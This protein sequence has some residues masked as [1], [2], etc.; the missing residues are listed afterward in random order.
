MC[1]RRPGVAAILI[2]VALALWGAVAPNA[3]AATGLE[4]F[5]PG[6]LIS[7]EAFFD[8]ETM[9]EEEIAAFIAGRGASCQPNPDGTPCLKDYRSDTPAMPDSP[10]C[11]AL[12]A[13]AGDS[14]AGMITRVAGAC[15]INPQ[16]L[17][18]LLQ[19]EQGFLTATG[20][21]LTPQKYSRA[22]G[23]GC[24]DFGTCD[25]TTATFFLQLYSAGERFQKYRVLS[26]SYTFQANSWEEIGYHPDSACGKARVFVQNQA[27][28]GL[29]NYTPY[30]PNEASLAAVAGTGDACS[31]YGNRNF[32]RYMKTWFPE[33][34]NTSD[35]APVAPT[36]LAPAP[37]A[38]APLA[39]APTAAAAPTSVP[40]QTA[41]P[42]PSTTASV[43]PG[44]AAI[45][46]AAA[47]AGADEVGTPASGP[48]CGP[49]S[50]T[51][52]YTL[53][54]YHWTPATGANFVRGAIGELWSAQGGTTGF[55][56]HPTSDEFC[57]LAQGGCGQHFEGGS[58]FHSPA[59][60]TFFSLGAIRDLW[61]DNAWEEGFLGYP[62]S[63][64]FC[65]LDQAGCAQHFQG[66]SIY[67]TPALG[68][69]FTRGLVRDLW[70]GRGWERGTLG[71][72]TTDEL[73]AADASCRQDFQG[74]AIAYTVAGGAVLA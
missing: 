17:L 48:E 74:G 22:L 35:A 29:Y 70:A 43:S 53:A 38:P 49:A 63:D 28:A 19:K 2:A 9:D 65:G 55:L 12:V 32:Y 16:V 23:A 34:M 67:H 36:P 47:D 13:I 18:V 52:R 15:G 69:H 41:S 45:T 7:D 1:R 73:C 42:V 11:R 54:T 26:G 51:Q 71:Y 3:G 37:T 68:S 4:G 72:P 10:Y 25:P 21:G 56:G 31:A 24:P 30:V 46:A 60:G 59:V 39:P 66:G 58:I 57:G 8:P 20:A 6:N 27:T 14:A 62:T 44:V 40:L 5:D 50:C 61:A 33:S 64:E